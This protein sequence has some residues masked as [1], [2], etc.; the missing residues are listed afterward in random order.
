[1]IKNKIRENIGIARKHC[2]NW[3]SGDCLGVIITHKDGMITQ[4]L[5]KSMYGKKCFADSDCDYFK[6]IVLPGI[7]NGH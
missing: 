2:A 6:H 5:K 3:N 1:V 4:R 7:N